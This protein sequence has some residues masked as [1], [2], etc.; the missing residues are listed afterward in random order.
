M[1]HK[2]TMLLVLSHDEMEHS[3]GEVIQNNFFE[4]NRFEGKKMKTVIIY[5]KVS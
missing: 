3:L 1:I 4:L 5:K 2:K